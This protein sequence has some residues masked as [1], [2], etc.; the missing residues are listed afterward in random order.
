MAS[1][2]ALL[3]VRI[4]RL[5]QNDMALNN[6]VCGMIIIGGGS[7]VLLY[8]LKRTAEG[9]GFGVQAGEPEGLASDVGTGIPGRSPG[10]D[11]YIA[12]RHTCIP[13]IIQL[14][15]HPE[16]SPG[17]RPEDPLAGPA[18]LSQR[19]LHRCD[20]KIETVLG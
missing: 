13:T 12:L 16:P 15:S 10:S 17:R 11:A 6:L 18:R 20:R 8:H 2:T 5:N 19:S 1:W 14:L 7:G 9:L 3:K 4:A